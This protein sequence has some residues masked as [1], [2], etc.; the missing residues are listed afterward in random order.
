VPACPICGEEHWHGGGRS[1][2][3]PRQYLFHRVRH[4][5]VEPTAEQE[6]A[7]Q[8]A[9]RDLGGYILVDERPQETERLLRDL[10]SM[11][12]SA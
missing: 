11:E 7:A 6:A 5:R 4:C 1:G 12:V 8:A 2:E 3:D 10:G 9:R